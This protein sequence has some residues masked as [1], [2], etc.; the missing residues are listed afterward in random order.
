MVSSELRKLFR[1]KL[2]LILMAL[3]ILSNC[4][5]TWREQLPGTSSY[6]NVRSEHIRALYAALPEDGEQALTA[7]EQREEI[8]GQA[9]FA[10]AFS[11]V[12]VTDPGPLLTGDLY[13]ERS[14]FSALISR[15]EPV[16]RYSALLEEIRDNGDALLLTGRYAPGSFPYENVIRS[17]QVYDKL[18][19][20]NP[21]LLYSGAVELLPGNGL[22]EIMVVLMALLIALE[23]I[24]TERSQG[25]L[26][27]CKPACKGSLSLILSKLFA[28]LLWGTLGTILLY[29][30][31][32]LIGLIRC[33]PVDFGAP[34]QSVFGM[35]RSPLRITIGEYIL[36]FL[37]V[38]LLWMGAVVSLACV[39][40]YVGRKLW[41][42][43]GIFLFLGIACFLRPGSMLN[44]FAR[45][46]SVEL[47]GTY[48]NLN[49]LGKPVSN[50]AVVVG[51][52]LLICLVAYGA[53]LILH[54]KQ[55]PMISERTRKRGR[56]PPALFFSLFLHEAWKLLIMN[57]AL[58]ILLALIPVQFFIYS[59]FPTYIAPMERLYIQYSQIL[60]GNPNADKEAFLTQEENRFADLYEQR[61]HYGSSLAR[62]E[63]TEEA[64]RALTAGIGRQLE[65]EPIFHRARDQYRT[66]EAE[67]LDYV[68]LSPYER[69]FGRLGQKNLLRQTLILILVLTMGLSGI[70][71]S[72]RETG[73]YHLIH[74]AERE[75][76]SRRRKLLL[77]IIYG[78]VAAI[79][80]YTPQI[81][82]IANLYGLPGLTA[83]AKSV[84]VFSVHFGTVWTTLAVYAV[85]SVSISAAISLLILHLSRMTKHTTYACLLALA[86]LL[87]VPVLVFLL[88]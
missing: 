79:F 52:L 53:A 6:T 39:A 75:E 85:I 46:S 51:I 30:S 23:L 32:L 78:I 54:I 63:I 57:G 27:L 50:L 67:N 19:E 13:S 43:M 56:R 21:R 12:P 82:V 61:D 5:V 58:W 9:V 24:Y 62:G 73:M 65:S 68:C 38:K 59:D 41:Q 2:T 35:I 26:A 33:G 18:W 71:A 66:V 36:L 55:A 20:T 34:I 74:T 48:W 86:L 4:L 47:F 88:L 40:S 15:V 80:V 42:C 84:P 22:T 81:I 14:L 70:H 69:L 77:A 1:N 17:R 64:Y 16:V 37:G 3:L 45:G 25:T 49:V 76:S 7:L 44:P 60:S 31:N 11:Q 72:E 28:G 87:P 29:G 83:P 10:E 8:L